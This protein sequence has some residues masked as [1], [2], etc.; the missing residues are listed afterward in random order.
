[1]HHQMVVQ[2]QCKYLPSVSDMSVAV[3]E[4]VSLFMNWGTFYDFVALYIAFTVSLLKGFHLQDICA[5][6]NCW[7][8]TKW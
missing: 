6:T 1:M 3:T 2:Y 5:K 7:L 8:K 4:N